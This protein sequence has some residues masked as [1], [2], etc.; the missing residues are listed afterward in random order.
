MRRE[1]SSPPGRGGWL[2]QPYSNTGEIGTSG[3][4][5]NL[6]SGKTGNVPSFQNTERRSLPLTQTSFLSR[7]TRRCS[8][9]E[10]V[11]SGTR[12]VRC[13]LA[14]SLNT[15]FSFPFYTKGDQQRCHDSFKNPDHKLGAVTGDERDHKIERLGFSTVA[16]S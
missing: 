6:R 13:C 14:R 12:P 8:N 10:T 3:T 11:G 1:P 9:F 4:F 5:P 16:A 2:A 7:G 15:S